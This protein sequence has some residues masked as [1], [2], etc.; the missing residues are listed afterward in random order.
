[1]SLP[2]K[3]NRLCR[4]TSLIAATAFIWT[5]VL[6]VSPALHERVHAVNPD[7]TCAVTF[8]SNGSC[9]H[10][11]APVFVVAPVNAACFSRVP[12]VVSTWVASPF[13]SASVF[14]HAPPLGI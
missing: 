11:S 8:V 3:R 12:A 1:M 6:S 9:D 4:W 5:L 14:E 13:L 2:M 7:H 10:S